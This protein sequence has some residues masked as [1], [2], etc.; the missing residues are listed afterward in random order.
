[1]ARSAYIYL[2]RIKATGTLIGAFTVK[3]EARTWTDRWR[4]G[5]YLL[6]DLQL[7]RMPD[8]G[9]ELP[10]KQGKNQDRVGKMKTP[11]RIYQLALSLW[12][13][14]VDKRGGPPGVPGPAGT[15]SRGT[16]T[17]RRRRPPSGS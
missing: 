1:M 3:H 9:Y 12:L 13:R 6:D 16:R 7:S 11:E 10:D 15:V 5:V 17:S 8:G 2:V 4:G 14:V